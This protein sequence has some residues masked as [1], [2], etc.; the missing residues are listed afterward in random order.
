MAVGK[1]KVTL[2]EWI[3]K[4]K[5]YV[6]KSLQYIGNFALAL[7]NKLLWTSSKSVK[8]PKKI[9][10]YR[11]GNIGDTLCAVPAMIAVKESYPK[12]HITLLTSPGKQGMPGARELLQNA[13]VLD[14]L[15]V[16]YQ[17]DINSLFKA[18]NKSFDNPNCLACLFSKSY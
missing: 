2:R 4:S 15:L 3:I 14:R 11:V 7:L 9:C 5:A 18:Y 16:Y 8:N 13:G 1:R 10:I 6:A 12:A 17:K